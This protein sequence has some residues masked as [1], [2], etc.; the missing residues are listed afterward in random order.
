MSPTRSGFISCA[1]TNAKRDGKND[2]LPINQ[3][4]GGFLE[5]RR[6]VALTFK[7]RACRPQSHSNYPETARLY[8]INWRSGGRKERWVTRL[9]G[10]GQLGR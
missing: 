5:L 6:A 7:G 4:I 8:R 3:D 9:T 2:K 10:D 1:E